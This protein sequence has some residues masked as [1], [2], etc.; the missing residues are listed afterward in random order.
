MSDEELKAR[1]KRGDNAFVYGDYVRLKGALTSQYKNAIRMVHKIPAQHADRT[2]VYD[3]H[4]DRATWEN[5]RLT[6]ATREE[7]VDY[8][9]GK[10]L[11]PREHQQ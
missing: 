7:Y 10:G 5:N 1:I 2:S 6:R 11:A 8:M 9:Q 4:G 3:L